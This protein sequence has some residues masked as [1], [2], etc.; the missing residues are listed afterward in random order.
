MSCEMVKNK[1]K[2]G[3]TKR[4]KCNSKYKVRKCVKCQRILC[5]ADYFNNKIHWC[6]TNIRRNENTFI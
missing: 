5:N 2:N 3:H 6:F 4:C 1:F